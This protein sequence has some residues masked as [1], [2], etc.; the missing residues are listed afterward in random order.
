MKFT[1]ELTTDPNFD[2]NS[3]NLISFRFCTWPIIETETSSGLDWDWA[4]PEYVTLTLC[5]AIVLKIEKEDKGED[6]QRQKKR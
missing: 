6:L 3:S 5:V 4:G 1:F 2:C